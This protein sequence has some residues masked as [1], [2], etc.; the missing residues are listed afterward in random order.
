M[1][2]WLR[3]DLPDA[4]RTALRLGFP[5]VDV[6]GAAEPT[7]DELGE[8]DVVFTFA[9]IPDDVVQRMPNLRWIQL[10]HG[11]A[12]GYLTPSVMERAIE[13]TTSTG[14]A[15]TPFAEFALACIFTLAKRLPE[16]W[17]AQQELRWDESIGPQP[18]EGRTLGIIGL[19]AI[20]SELARKAKALGLRV[21]ANKRHVVAAP[22]FVDELGTRE[23]LPALLAQ[24]DYVV[25]CLP[26]V[27]KDVL[28]EKELMSMKPGSFLVN[29]TGRQSIPDEAALVRAL[30]DGPIAGAVLNTFPDGQRELPPESEL[31][32]L[33]NVIITPRIAGQ[34]RP[35]WNE[36]MALFEDNLNRFLEGKPLRNVVDKELGYTRTSA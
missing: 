26:S 14:V 17:Q 18:V 9:P 22:D 24:S 27:E 6:L 8:V 30:K 19:G 1:R 10:Q 11:G 3:L 28:R 16:C 35:M 12:A 2:L 21:L 33:P 20:G 15:A 34:Q 5:Q 32:R 13:V 29:L 25:L 31:W 36:V 23:F 4:E 7:N